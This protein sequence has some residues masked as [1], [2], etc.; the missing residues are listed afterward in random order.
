MSLFA[1]IMVVLNFILAVVF[2]ASAGT[3]LGAMDNWKQQ[4]ANLKSSTDTTIKEKDGTISSLDGQLAQM[5]QAKEAAEKSKALAEQAQASLQE[6]NETLNRNN[7]E[8]RGSLKQLSDTHQSV[9][10]ANNRLQSEKAELSNKLETAQGDKR[11]AL[12][13]VDTANQRIAQLEGELRD[14]TANLAAQ[15]K[16]NVSQAEKIDALTTS[17]RLYEKTFGA[18]PE[19][20]QMVPVNGKVQ[21]VD[22]AMD[23]FVISVGAKDKVAVGY[24]FT[25]SRGNDY[26]STIVVDTVYPNHAAC[27]TKQGMKKSDVQPGDN[28]ATLP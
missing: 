13:Q 8:L 21:S 16:A 1:K 6:S 12:D 20:I 23:I 2:L 24:E 5:R 18:L 14:A 9:V 28:V 4:H 3:F 15:E 19:A 17:L 10:D 27:R 26:V 7:A 22:N 25:V 11:D